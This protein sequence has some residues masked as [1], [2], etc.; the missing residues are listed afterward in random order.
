M[1]TLLH[2]LLSFGLCLMA[3]CGGQTSASTATAAQ[4]SVPFKG[5][6]Q[7]FAVPRAEVIPS[8]VNM[9]LRVYDAGAIW[10]DRAGGL[11]PDATRLTDYLPPRLSNSCASSGCDFFITSQAVANAG[12]NL[13][14]LVNAGAQTDGSLWAPV[15][16]NFVDQFNLVNAQQ[17]RG[18]LQATA[19]AYAMSQYALRQLATQVNLG[20]TNTLLAHGLVIGLVRTKDPTDYSGGLPAGIAGAKIFLTD[21]QAQ[22]VDLYYPNDDYSAST[23]TSD[24]NADGAFLL[25]G[26]VPGAQLA[27]TTLKIQASTS[28]DLWT[29]RPIA[30]IAGSVVIA[31]LSAVP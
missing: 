21:A 11:T 1:K 9:Q 5:H 6:I 24:T 30:M 8:F 3:A 26:R 23:G 12:P 31:P 18:T 15:Y 14:S 27:P 10:T 22:A 16:T 28:T 2:A 13:V 29:N 20:D 25:V 7:A 17:Q 19:P 4:V